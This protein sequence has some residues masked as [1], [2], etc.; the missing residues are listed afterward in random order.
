MGAVTLF[1][2][3][4]LMTGRGIDQVLPHPSDPAIHEPYA[5]SALEYVVLAE[6]AAGRIPRHV[7]FAYI[8]GDALGE[9]EARRPDVSV[10]NLETSVTTSQEA[11]PKGIN[12]RMHPRNVRCL[13]AAGLDCCVLAN[14]HVLD[15][16]ATGLTETLET[17]EGAG[18]ATAGA[19][20]DAEEAAAPAVLP[21]PGGGRAL[22]FGVASPTSGVAASWAATGDRPGVAVLPDL[23][24]RAAEGLAAR[25]WARRRPGDLVVVSV[26]WGGNWGY[27][28]PAEQRDFARRL[29]DDAGADVVH[30]HS[31]HHAKGIEVYRG[32]PILYGC[33]DFIND[34]EGIAGYE[35]F[36]SEL[37]LAY[38]VRSDAASGTIA[39]MRMVPFRSVRFRL[40]RADKSEAEWL[41]VMLEREGEPLGTGAVHSK[42]DTLELRF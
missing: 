41:R 42:N 19:G 3:G 14:N 16:G 38:F 8:W 12:Y 10:A 27:A 32:R 18:I 39:G 24:V 15:W 37:V 33:G 13:T 23:S 2:C 31:S 26:H 5:G 20:R 25:V 36:R 40:R 21:L 30:G 29:I 4:D 28:I 7:D 22:V 17:L 9:L 6:G 1:L 35:G 34:Y 11:E